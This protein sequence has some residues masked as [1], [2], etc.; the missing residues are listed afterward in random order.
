MKYQNWIITVYIITLILLSVVSINGDMA[1]SRRH[2]GGIR[3][4][5][6]IHAV[7]FVPWMI[8]ANLR[9]NQ[10]NKCKIFWCLLGIGVILAIV[11]EIVQLLIPKKAFNP[12]DLAANG[13]GIVFGAMIWV[14]LVSTESIPKKP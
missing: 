10:S 6:I 7:F 4:D 13:V 12:I 8:L 9:W 1:P 3:T 2:W 11:S 5:Y 14:L